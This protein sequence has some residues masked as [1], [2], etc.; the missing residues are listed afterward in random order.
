[1]IFTT[2]DD[3]RSGL[4]VCSISDTTFILRGNCSALCS[5]ELR[6]LAIVTYLSG[7]IAFALRHSYNKCLLHESRVSANN[8]ASSGSRLV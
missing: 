1:M 6:T 2:R 5:A 7:M 8:H 4:V 3:E